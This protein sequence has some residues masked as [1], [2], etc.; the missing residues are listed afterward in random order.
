[1]AT[2]VP[3]NNRSKASRKT[4]HAL[5][6]ARLGDMNASSNQVIHPMQAEFPFYRPEN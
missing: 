5:R 1:M 2:K 6:V 4:S 3:L